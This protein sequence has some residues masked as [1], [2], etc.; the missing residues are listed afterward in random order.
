MSDAT[1]KVDIW[2]I[3][4]PEGETLRANSTA[5]VRHHIETGKIP[6]TSWVRRDPEA[7]WTPLEWVG[8]FADLLGGTRR[9]RSDTTE[10]PRSGPLPA[11][12]RPGSTPDRPSGSHE[13]M[14]SATSKVPS[15]S[16]SSPAAAKGQTG[17]ASRLDPM[18]LK[19]IGVRGFG[20][21]LLAAMDQTLV[22]GKLVTGCVTGMALWGV[23]IG[24]PRLMA[25][26]G[27][28]PSW[29]ATLIVDAVQLLI[30]AYA[31]TLLIRITQEE[32]TRMKLVRLSDVT[33]GASTFALRLYGG[34]LLLAG[35]AGTLLT[36]LRHSPQ[37]LGTL[38]QELDLGL[39]MLEVLATIIHVVTLLVAVGYWLLIGL[40]WLLGPVLIFEEPPLGTAIREWASLI[41]KHWRQLMLYEGLALILGMAITLPLGVPVA[42]AY[43]GGPL[44]VSGLPQQLTLAVLAGTAAGPLLAFLAVA[45]TFIY[46]NLRYES[47]SR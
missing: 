34:Y 10:G 33:P 19:T 2:Y 39:S 16:E 31:N 7:E 44:L 30:L 28:G 15:A 18:R 11:M 45:N 43:F 41:R 6:R 21:E 32:V 13:A 40:M 1:E 27:I 8:D 29:L 38:A 9:S 36:L 12:P 22:S 47:P 42:L 24:V 37:W 17:V 23:L 35:I 5:A 20:E 4:L 25:E 14:K 46:L 26:I 3:R